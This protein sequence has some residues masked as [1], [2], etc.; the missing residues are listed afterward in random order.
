MCEKQDA[1]EYDVGM[2]CSMVMLDNVIVTTMCFL[3][4]LFYCFIVLR[5]LPTRIDRFR[6]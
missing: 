2:D 5:L 3:L 4:G 6:S 1:V